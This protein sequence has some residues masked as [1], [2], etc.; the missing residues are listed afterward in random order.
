[1]VATSRRLLREGTPW[2]RL[3]ATEDQTSGSTLRRRLARWAE[4]GLLAKVHALL[5]G[6]LRGHPDLILDTRPVRAKRGGDMT[7]PNPTDRGKRGT[8]YHI[9]TDGDGVPVAC[10]ATA[11]NVNDT[12]LFERLFLAAFAVMAR[13][14]TVFADRGYDAE[15]HRGLCRAFGAEPRIHKRGRPCGSGLGQRRWPVERSNAWV[16]ENER[17]ALRYDRL[18]L[19]V[20]S[21]LQAACIFLV[22]GRLAREL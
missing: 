2:R 3:D 16:L 22:A 17:L 6:M 13:I 15:H 10:A 9:A 21:L 18:G 5:V 7:G 4:T 1:V 19:V 12:L 8:K 20:R 11:A 14:R